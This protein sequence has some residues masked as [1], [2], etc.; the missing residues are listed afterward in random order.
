M[1][2]IV[3]SSEAEDYARVSC[4]AELV[5]VE[6]VRAHGVRAETQGPARFEGQVH[7]TAQLVGEGVL[8]AGGRLRREVRITDQGMRPE[9]DP[10]ARGPA[11]ARTA[12]AEQEPRA[13]V[14]LSCVGRGEFA[15]QAEPILNS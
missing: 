1:T 12:A 8:I 10:F 5:G 11:E 3:A 2:M 14:V 9:F 13:D 15:I 7:A 4:G 6:V